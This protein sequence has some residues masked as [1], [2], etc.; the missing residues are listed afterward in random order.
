LTS[1]QTDLLAFG[2]TAVTATLPL[3]TEALDTAAVR[4][5]IT[6]PDLGF[7]ADALVGTRPRKITSLGD[8]EVALRLGLVQHPAFRAVLA[9]TLRLPTGKRDSPRNL[10]DISTGDRQMDVEVGLELAVEPGSWLGLSL[11]GSYTL[12]M[13]DE[14]PL[15][16]TSPHLPIALAANERTVQRDLGDIIHVRAY[17][18]IR[19][20]E[21]FRVFGSASYI[22]KA[23][24]VYTSTGGTDPAFAT[25]TDL[26]IDSRVEVWSFGG[27]IS[28]RAS[29]GRRGTGLPIEAGLASQTA[30]FGEGGLTP[31]G[32]SVGLHLRLFYRIF[33]SSPEAPAEAESSG[34]AR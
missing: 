14:L 5:V 2:A 19:L 10:V 6:D 16:V 24:D 25:V 30:F 34:G 27:G 32:T 31:K 7:D 13:A 26:A 21:S 18:T 12:Q 17:P 20:N 11:F 9:G 29:G 23:A 28:Y 22:R 3:P 33:G 15:R 8:A 1:L 4:S